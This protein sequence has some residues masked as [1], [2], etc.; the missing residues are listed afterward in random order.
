M[1][2]LPEGWGSRTRSA[3]LVRLRRGRRT[4]DLHV[5]VVGPMTSEAVAL[6]AAIGE[7]RPEDPAIPH[8]EFVVIAGLLESWRARALDVV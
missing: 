8:R 1:I 2:T 5:D 6:V 3:D 7:G 4:E